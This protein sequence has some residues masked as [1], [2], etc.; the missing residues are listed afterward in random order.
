M[1]CRLS[2]EF[3]IGITFSFARG[4]ALFVSYPYVLA[5][6]MELSSFPGYVEISLVSTAC[7]Y[8]TIPGKTGNSI[9]CTVVKRSVKLV[10]IH[11][12]H[13]LP[14]HQ[15]EA[16]GTRYAVLFYMCT[17]GINSLTDK[18]VFHWKSVLAHG[19]IKWFSLRFSAPKLHTHAHAVILYTLVRYYVASGIDYTAC[20]IN[21]D[22]TY[23]S[24]GIQ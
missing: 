10:H 13:A 1:T 21:S 2:S 22:R 15:K 16:K 19:C 11:L 18:I 24:M 8:V 5:G 9:L 4:H 3:A 12:N 14:Y 20:I 23:P 17:F 7:A 6:G